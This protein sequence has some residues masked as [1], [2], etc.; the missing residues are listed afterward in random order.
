MS[1]GSGI[2]DQEAFELLQREPGG[3]YSPEQG[4]SLCRELELPLLCSPAPGQLSPSALQ[5]VW[6]IRSCH[7]QT[8]AI[9]TSLISVISFPKP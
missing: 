5:R 6:T 7:S 3:G 1:E 8:H 9:K 2:L 4:L